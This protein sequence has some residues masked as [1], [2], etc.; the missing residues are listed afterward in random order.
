MAEKKYDYIKLEQQ[1]D[2]SKYN[3]VKSFLVAILGLSDKQAK[4]SFWRGKTRGWAKRKR[5][6]LQQID[7]KRRNKSI[8][9]SAIPLDLTEW[10]K[11]LRDSKKKLFEIA[12]KT[13]EKADEA[14]LGDIKTI[15]SIKILVDLLKIELGEHTSIV[16]SNN[17]NTDRVV[18]SKE[19]DKKIKEK[20]NDAIKED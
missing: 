8:E 1:F 16:S 18:I 20:I 15:N 5:E 10:N 19:I 12:F 4:S 13:I 9:D 7:E 14:K 3:Q 17:T 6:F 11:K 2:E